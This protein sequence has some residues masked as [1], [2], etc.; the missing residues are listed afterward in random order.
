MTSWP[1]RASPIFALAGQA[2]CAAPLVLAACVAV[3]GCA[4]DGPKRCTAA[5]VASLPLQAGSGHVFTDVM[6]NGQN[7]RMIVDTGA[8]ITVVSRVTANRL[9]LRAVPAGEA[10]GIG[11]WTSASLFYTN[12]FQL[13]RL[14]GKRFPLLVSDINFPIGANDA[15]GLLGT[16]FLSSYDI[17]FD[18]FAQRMNFL[19]L[20]GPCSAGSAF[21]DG[22]LFHAKLLPSGHTLDFRPRVAVRIG[23]RRFVALID[24]G[25]PRSV[26]FRDAA[27][28]AGLEMDAPGA[29]PVAAARGVGGRGVSA[30]LLVAPLVNVGE[31]GVHNMPVEVIDQYASGDDADMI[32]GMDFMARVHAWF[33]F[34]TQTLIMQ[35]PP[36]PSPVAR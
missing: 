24:T 30:V 3:A 36:R 16:D 32:I 6:L 21:M 2:T 28:L 25:A 27:H 12:S 26:M 31:I 1:C 20:T 8:N 11:G 33:S 14:R 17:D 23:G 18:V 13:G 7:V 29:R 10:N 22:P 4:A 19:T 9:G 5:R 15:D 34:A 35:Y